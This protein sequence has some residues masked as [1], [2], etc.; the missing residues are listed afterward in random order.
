M[1]KILP[2]ILVV[3]TVAVIAAGSLIDGERDGAVAAKTLYTSALV[4]ASVASDASAGAAGYVVYLDPATG[5]F[6]D[7]PQNAAPLMI[8]E[9]LRNALSTSSEGLVEVTTPG[10]AVF[11]DLQGR[12]QS[13]MIASVDSN[14]ELRA[15]CISSLPHRHT[16][17][18]DHTADASRSHEGGE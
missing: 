8:D 12:F 10:G 15:S 17:G 7:S 16:S 3:V 2:L 14:G 13:A 6:T 5:K 4:G 11:V 18:C 9:E 1:R